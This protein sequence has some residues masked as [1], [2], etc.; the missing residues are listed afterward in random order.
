M[1]QTN[2]YQTSIILNSSCSWQVGNRAFKNEWRVVKIR[3]IDSE[4]SKTVAWAIVGN[5]LIQFLPAFLFAISI[6]FNVLGMTLNCI[7]IF[8]GTD[9]LYVLMCRKAV[10]RSI[11]QSSSSARSQFLGSSRATHSTTNTSDDVAHLFTFTSLASNS[12]NESILNRLYTR[13]TRPSFTSQRLPSNT[14]HHHYTITLHHV[15]FALPPSNFSANLVSTL[16]SCLSLFLTCWPFS[17]DNRNVFNLALAAYRCK[18]RQKIEDRDE[19]KVITAA[20]PR[21][22]QGEASKRQGEAEA[23]LLLPR[24]RLLPRDIHHWQSF[25]QYCQHDDWNSLILNSYTFVFF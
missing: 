12:D 17:L 24:A 5:R 13:V 8:L 14:C 7:Y 4:T 10:N 15:R 23:V 16:L 6:V 25:D 11:N 19:A 20:R 21:Q 22:D 9:S 1:N 18:A 2:L 3:N